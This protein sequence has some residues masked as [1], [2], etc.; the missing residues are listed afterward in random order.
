MAET[1]QHG[2]IVAVTENVLRTVFVYITENS[3]K[4]MSATFGKY[5]LRSKDATVEVVGTNDKRV[6][7]S[8][9]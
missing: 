7:Y 8:T 3:F 9:E 2:D 5:R 4:K 6:F 1:P